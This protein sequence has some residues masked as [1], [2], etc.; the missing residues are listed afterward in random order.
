MAWGLFGSDFRYNTKGTICKEKKLDL[1]KVFKF[2]FAKVDCKRMKNE[3]IDLD[4]ILTKGIAGKR[5]LFKT[6]R[7]LKNQL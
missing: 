6:Y 1:N 3:L 5:M 7:C 2:C 4:K